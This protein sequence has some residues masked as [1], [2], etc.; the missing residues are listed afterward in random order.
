MQWEKKRNGVKEMT[1]VLSALACVDEMLYLIPNPSSPPRPEKGSSL[2]TL[3]LPRLCLSLFF[4]LNVNWVF[5][6]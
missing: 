3:S 4:L 2:S 6:K 5:L 1:V